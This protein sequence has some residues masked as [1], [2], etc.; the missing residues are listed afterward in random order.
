MAQDFETYYLKN[1]Y[2]TPEPTDDLLVLTFD[3]KGI[4]MRPDSLRECT[5]KKAKTSQKLHSRLSAG[6]KKDRKRMAQ[7][8]SVYTV[9]PHYRSAESIMKCEDNNVH[10]IGAPARNKRIWTECH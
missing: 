3:W 2:N 10:N 4:V 8:G 1:R 5:K 6:E 7:V 9:L